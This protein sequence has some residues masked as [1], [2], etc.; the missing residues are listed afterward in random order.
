MAR[1]MRLPETAAPAG[2]ALDPS[3]LTL[4]ATIAD[5]GSLTA[6]AR[7]LGAT[8]P[9][10]S[11]QLQRIEQS[12]GVPVFERSMRGVT[13]TAYGSAL[14]PRA[15]T[16]AAQARQALEEVA[17]L[18]GEREG[19]LHVALSHLATLALLPQVV[20]P[21][22]DAWPQVAL[23]IG[24]PTFR[25]AGLREGAP[26]FAVVSLPAERLG[27]E[28]AARPIYTGTVA[29]VVR[30][31]HPLARARTLAALAGADWV[32]PSPDSSTA[33]S[34]QRAFRRAR[35]PAPR[36]TVTCETLT[37]LETL[38]ASTDLIGALPAEVHERR[39]SASGFVRLPLDVAIEGA[40]VA[41]VR[42]ADAR[43][44]PASAAMQELFADAAHRLAR[45]R[46]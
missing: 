17:Q 37:G 12:L 13:P 14:L 34:L 46:R 38:V 41:I 3:S 30:R 2:P 45:R 10:L 5:A 24:P 39:A 25:F 28:F 4:L 22:R 15:R 44:T 29:V 21:F 7:A 42:W 31:G 36:C 20:G 1:R 27:S 35:L 26:D 6:A 43:P 32:V 40:R 11:K 19:A 9:A 23:R 16:I 8:Q 33:L 18:R